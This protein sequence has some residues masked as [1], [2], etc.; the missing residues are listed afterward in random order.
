MYESG[1]SDEPAPAAGVGGGPRCG[2]P[3]SRSEAL[4]V[5]AARNGAFTAA[6][7]ALAQAGGS[8]SSSSSSSAAA[9]P[10]KMAL[11]SSPSWTTSTTR[12]VGG[13]ETTAFLSA[14]RPTAAA[15]RPAAEGASIFIAGNSGNVPGGLHRGAAPRALAVP[16]LDEDVL[17]RCQAPCS[18]TSRKPSSRAAGPSEPTR[19]GARLE[20]RRRRR[21]PPSPARRLGVQRSA[22]RAGCSACASR[23]RLRR[24]RA[25]ARPQA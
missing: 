11:A 7:A 13:L 8:S 24:T 12:C 5:A 4:F 14:A 16:G 22:V 25:R 6:L 23:P 19:E 9:S 18:R 15:E 2:Q 1:A 21:S 20:R 10:S 3:A 17:K